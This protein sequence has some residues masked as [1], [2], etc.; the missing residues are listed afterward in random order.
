LRRV[1]LAIVFS[2]TVFLAS[3]VFSERTASAQIHWDAS[4]HGG[5][6]K[7]F[8]S[9]RLPGTGDAM[10]GP[11]IGLQGHIALIPFVR[12]G[13]YGSWDMSPIDGG[14]SPPR[15]FFSIGGQGKIYSPLPS[16]D[17]RLFLTLGFGYTGAFAP[18]G[19]NV[20]LRPS[21][22][23]QSGKVFMGTVDDA[24]GGF[25]EIPVGIGVSYKLRDTFVV[26]A[27]LL[28]RFGFGFWGRLYGEKGGRNAH[29]P[30][31]GNQAIGKDGNDVF[32]LG[33]VLGVG[34]DK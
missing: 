4:V 13:L 34:L 30:T 31:L 8:L 26:Y 11:T 16:G 18:G 1:I 33:L 2:A 22:A 21:D 28:S 10:F 14:A 9:D 23:S 12:V 3:T 20:L 27:E 7:R 5:V 24:G 25:A 19:Y 15:Q 17:L 29:E 32:A 6:Y